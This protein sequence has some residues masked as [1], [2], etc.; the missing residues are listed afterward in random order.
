MEKRKLSYYLIVYGLSFIVMLMLMIFSYTRVNAETGE[1]GYFVSNSINVSGSMADEFFMFGRSFKIGLFLIDTAALILFPLA[2]TLVF[3]LLDLGRGRVGKKSKEQSNKESYEKFIDDIGNTLNQT[4]LFNAEDYRHFRENSKFQE[5]L[6]SLYD[7]YVNG[8]S[9]THSYYLLMRKFDKGTK[10]R[11]AIEFLIT[12][13]E[14]KR[15][16]LEEKRKAVEETQTQTENKD[17]L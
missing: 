11:D 3:L 14:K 6:K 5:C 17:E 8:E 1:Y 13:A 10:E 12:F 16:E 7:I 4:H 9:E 2:L 15:K